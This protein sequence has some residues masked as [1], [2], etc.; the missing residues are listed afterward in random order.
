MLTPYRVLDLTDHR[1]EIAGMIL[2]DLGADVIKVEPPGGTSAR[3]CEPRLPSGPE[4]ERSLQFFAYN[5]NKRSIVLDLAS[6]R[7]RDTFLR[8]VENSDF[9]LESGYPGSLAPQEL[10]FEILR[11]ANSRIVHVQI[12][13]FGTDGPRA[14]WVGSDLVLA[15]M[16]GPVAL[17]GVAE[18]PPVRVSVPQAWRHTGGE[19]AIA[20]LVGHARMR[21]T[22]EAQFVD[23]SAQC[24]MTWTL[25]N[26]MD[27]EAIQGHDFK[28]FGSMLQLGGGHPSSR[29]RLRRRL[30]RPAR[31]G[32]DDRRGGALDGRR[33][34]GGR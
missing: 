12:T 13:P 32:R 33:G 21:R 30:R 24:A 25:L 2:A 29:F 23:V 15:A 11:A 34:R 18:R 5:R 31:D 27:T 14:N 28:R 1:G 10:G 22:G 3:R 8:L 17:Q 19:A 20:A 26:A 6:G 16:G 7:D 9:V 4:A